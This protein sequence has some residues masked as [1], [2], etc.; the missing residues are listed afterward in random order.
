MLVLGLLF[1]A[2]V[3][4]QSLVTFRLDLSDEI[5]N[6]IFNPELDQAELL[7]DRPPLSLTE[8]TP[9]HTGSAGNHLYMVTIEFPQS[10]VGK[11]LHYRFALT[12]SGTYQREN[13]DPPRRVVLTPGKKVLQPVQFRL[14]FQLFDS[15]VPSNSDNLLGMR[16]LNYE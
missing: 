14:D 10:A 8:G 11:E 16:F 3:Y 9:L 1:P 2:M 4:S 6:H 7:G 13:P 5:T 12:L 15:R